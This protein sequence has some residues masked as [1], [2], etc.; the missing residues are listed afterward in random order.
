MEN[1]ELKKLI[2]NALV[3]LEKKYFESKE[4]VIK[5]FIDEYKKALSTT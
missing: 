5:T 3:L 1:S 2:E 4:D